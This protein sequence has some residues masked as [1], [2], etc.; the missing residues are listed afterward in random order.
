M[1]KLLLLV[2]ICIPAFLFGQTPT[3]AVMM[4]Q[5]QS[6]LAV[7]YDR[8]SW[9]HYWE[10]TYLR[11]NAN[12]GTLN[13]RMILPMI[14][15]GLHDKLNLIV[16]LPHVK[17][18]SSAEAG[19]RMQGA[20]GLQDIGL[21]LKAEALKK[22]IGKGKLSLLGNVGFSTP[23]TNYLSDYLPY[24][25]GSGAPEFSLRGIAQYKLNNGFYV[26]TSLAQLWR[27]VTEI[28][29][30]YYYNNGSYYTNKMDVPNAWNFNG[31]LG[32]WLLK[33]GLK[34]E[35]TYMSSICTSGDD[36][37]KYNAG[38]PTNKVEVGQVGFNTQ[39]YIKKIKGLGVL[40]YYT[41]MISGR[42]MGEFTNVGGGVTYQFK[43]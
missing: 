26:Q 6:C 19:G 36:I 37:R 38:Q 16:S 23:M 28:E 2:S 40:A 24:S 25:I 17:T 27:G 1:K 4:K 13:R 20:S 3:D 30:D 29:R 18:E 31:A 35:A 5:R 10:G 33:D 15:I 11:T 14:A 9:D 32:V 21:N 41:K 22:E 39:F 34:L 8:G 42:N 43:L 7:I 12:V